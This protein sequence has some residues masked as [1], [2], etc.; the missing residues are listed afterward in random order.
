MMDYKKINK[1]INLVILQ[2]DFYYLTPKQIKN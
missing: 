2:K 1:Q